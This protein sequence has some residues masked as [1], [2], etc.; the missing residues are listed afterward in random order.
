[1]IVDKK[2]L[3]VK[4]LNYPNILFCANNKKP[5]KF[6]LNFCGFLL[7]LIGNNA[8]DGINSAFHGF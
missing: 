4:C 3:G 8:D 6:L 2:C 1:M 5:Q 7:L